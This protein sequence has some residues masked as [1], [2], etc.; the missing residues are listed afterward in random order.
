VTLLAVPNVSEGRDAGTIEAIAAGFSGNGARLLDIHSDP[1]HHRSVFTLAGDPGKL[2]YAVLRG[3]AETVKRIDLERH[4]GHHP[5]VGAIDVAPIVY[6]EDSDRG[7][8]C[9]EALV[10]GDLLGAE[11][12]LPVFLYGLLAQS[13]TRAELRRGGLPELRNRMESG[14]LAP[15]FGPLRLHP[16]AGAVLVAARP[17]LV[18]F[19]LELAPPATLEQAMEIAG[20]I[21]EGGPEGIPGVRAIGLWLDARGVAQVST[22]V[23]EHRIVPLKDV[24]AAVGRRAPVAAAELVGLPPRAALEGFPAEVP[25]RNARTIEDALAHDRRC[26][27]GGGDDH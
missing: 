15:D 1:D 19:N 8:A 24:V 27:P 11:L 16:T 25:L 9:A 2:A 17:P 10:L 18:A 6:L 3:A 23:E 22:N 21:R 20:S 26:A 13:R 4:S 7:A 12:D 14:E 5:R